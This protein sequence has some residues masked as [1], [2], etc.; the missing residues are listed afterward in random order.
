MPP[1]VKRDPEDSPG[2]NESSMPACLCMLTWI[3]Q[4]RATTKQLS[5]TLASYR[6]DDRVTQLVCTEVVKTT[7]IILVSKRIV[8]QTT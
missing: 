1:P 3:L 8:S 5:M 6:I 2:Q 7:P 4:Q